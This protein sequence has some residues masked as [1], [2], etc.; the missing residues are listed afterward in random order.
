MDM[1]AIDRAIERYAQDGDDQDKARFEFFRGLWQ[2]QQDEAERIGADGYEAAGDEELEKQ[3]WDEVPA[4]RENP[5]AIDAD[6][7]ARTCGLVA[8]YMA[9]NAGLADEVAGVLRDYDWKA[10]A[11]K[12]PL[13]LAGSDPA[14][15]VEACLG[16]IDDYE[17]D[18]SCPASVFMM[19]PSFAVRSY[20]QPAAEKLKDGFKAARANQLYHGKPLRCPACGAPAS[21]SSVASGTDIESHD[22]ILYCGLCG[23]TWEF[24]RI[25]CAC[26]GSQ[27]QGKLHW[28]HI[29]GDAA[30]R[31]H[32][33]EECGDYMRTVFQDDL[34]AA[35]VMEVED[36]AMARLDHVALDPRFRQ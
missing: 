15:F 5:V 27:N 3:Y 35:V 19:V 9:Q 22:R 33:C 26:C 13:D 11:A 2:I 10:F 36:V 31:L 21:A 6:E 8:D 28:F 29:E 12:A 23:T 4:F 14:G 25:R 34:G 17:L 24:E 32:N 18:S 1:K 30:H 20:L 7:F 16:A